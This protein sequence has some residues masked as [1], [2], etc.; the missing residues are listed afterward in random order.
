MDTSLASRAEPSLAYSRPIGRLLLWPKEPSIAA[1]YHDLDS[2]EVD[3]YGTPSTLTTHIR[4]E[5]PLDNTFPATDDWIRRLSTRGR[6]YDE[7]V[8]QL[9]EL[10]LRAAG[11]QVNRMREAAAL[12]ATR[13]EEIIH[14]AAD[15]AAMSVL[16]K[17]SSFE[18]RSAFSTWAYKFGI[19]QA[20]NEVRRSAWHGREINLD[21]IPEQHQ[22]M[23]QSPE[24]YV[25]GRDL[26]EAVRD[27]LRNALTPHQRRVAVAVLIDDIPIDVLAD[28]LS[29]NRNALY[30]TLHDARLRLRA[31]LLAHDF[32]VPTSPRKEVP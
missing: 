1:E 4:E 32:L 27:G 24:M 13:R 28:R 21:D 31:Y 14:S 30:K 18:G 17:L 22:T 20:A 11:S 2:C 8:A 7:A 5:T 10:L 25:E 15:D 9:H 19:L 3:F 26:A 16:S 12:G 23:A 29:I 6:V